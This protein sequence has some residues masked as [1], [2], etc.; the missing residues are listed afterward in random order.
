MWNNFVIA[1]HQ[2]LPKKSNTKDVFNHSTFNA[3]CFHFNV[4]ILITRLLPVVLFLTAY[5]KAVVEREGLMSVPVCELYTK[6]VLSRAGQLVNVLIPQPVLCR[7]TPKT[8]WWQKENTMMRMNIP[9]EILFINLFYND[10]WLLSSHNDKI[11]TQEDC[12]M[13]RMDFSHLFVDL[14][15]VN[16]K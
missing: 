5:L 4:W 10:Y 8:L 9:V 1:N 2:K 13:K 11:A 7:H 6:G 16:Q 14:L 3:N 12:W 15:S